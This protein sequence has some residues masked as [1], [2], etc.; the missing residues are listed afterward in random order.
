MESEQKYSSIQPNT[1]DTMHGCSSRLPCYVFCIC[2]L[3]QQEVVTPYTAKFGN[4]G[5]YSDFGNSGKTGDSDDSVNSD[6]LG[7]FGDFC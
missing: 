1:T 7:E 4:F 6:D 5:E 2:L 3:T